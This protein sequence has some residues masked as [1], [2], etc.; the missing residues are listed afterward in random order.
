MQL[1]AD[2]DGDGF[3]DIMRVYDQAKDEN[4]EPGADPPI[5]SPKIEFY[6]NR[7]T[8]GRG[9]LQS[10]RTA[11]NGTINL[12]YGFSSQTELS[13]SSPWTILP[14]SVEVIQQVEDG[15]GTRNYKFGNGHHD[16]QLNRFAGF[17]DAFVYYDN[18][19]TTHL[20]F[21]TS[22]YL[23]GDLLSRAEYSARDTDG[24]GLGDLEFFTL[25]RYQL[26]HSL[27]SPDITPPFFNP[28][29]ARC[30]FWLAKPVSDP[31]TLEQACCNSLSNCGKNVILTGYDSFGAVGSVGQAQFADISQSSSLPDHLSAVKPDTPTRMDPPVSATEY[32]F[33]AQE[34]QYDSD[35]RLI[36][37]YDHRD[38]PLGT[39]DDI[40]T[41][42]AWDAWSPPN[43]GK[44]LESITQTDVSG[45]LITTEQHS[46]FADFNQPQTIT[47]VGPGACDTQ[48]ES[49]TWQYT[50]DRG[51]IATITNPIGSVT[52]YD[53][54]DCGQIATLTDGDR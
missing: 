37:G 34:W 53:H 38:V 19:R 2:W 12:A 40:L 36:S 32:L 21:S 1:L 49:R 18:G 16:T 23:L 15:A 7:R 45:G 41:S 39:A 24:D 47:E 14:Y 43:A 51:E 9:R 33:T 27:S 13:S 50:Y 48:G 11:W 44:Q 35:Q 3:T 29:Q 4:S 17:G 52:R 26:E 42:Y 31:N 8:V 6:R 20:Q 5:L 46:R 54:N 30:D 22:D 10:I 28:L 25:L